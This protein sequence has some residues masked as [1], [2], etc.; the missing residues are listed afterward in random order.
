MVFSSFLSKKGI[1]KSN[2]SVISAVVPDY[3]CGDKDLNFAIKPFLSNQV[4]AEHCL[5]T[6]LH[7]MAYL[8]KMQIKDNIC[9]IECL[10]DILEGATW[11]TE[12][13][14]YKSGDYD[15]NNPDRWLGCIYS[16]Y[17]DYSEQNNEQYDELK[18]IVNGREYTPLQALEMIKTH[19]DKIYGHQSAY[20][21]ME[22]CLVTSEHH[23]N[24]SYISSNI[25]DMGYQL[26]P[27]YNKIKEK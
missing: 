14:G 7:Q 8:P 4:S 3:D 18:R 9:I 24:P 1:A 12:W 22:F 20:E 10:K 16:A 2:P 6:I 26:A 21:A 5:E 15:P 27:I 11:M 13:D 23:S 17:Y 19:W 25:R